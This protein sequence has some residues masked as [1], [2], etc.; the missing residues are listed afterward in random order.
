MENTVLLSTAYFA[1]IQYYSKLIQFP[2]VI[3][4][5]FENYSKQ[6]YRNRCTIFAANGALALSVPVLKASSKKILTKD[7]RISYDTNWQKLHWKGIESAY[8]SSPFYEFYID[9]FARFFDRKWDFL[10]DFNMEIQNQ[11]ISLIDLES[12]IRTTDDY[13]EDVGNLVDFRDGIHPKASKSIIDPSFESKEYYQ[14]FSDKFGFI[15]NLSILDLLFNLG[16]D[17]QLYLEQSVKG[18]KVKG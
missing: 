12:T 13:I 2:N 6:S 17:S 5:Q 9:D 8:N 3:I 11:V 1:P 18:L 4:E 16:P 7:V 15:E 10:L 14:V